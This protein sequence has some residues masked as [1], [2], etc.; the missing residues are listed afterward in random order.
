MGTAGKTRGLGTGV[1][2]DAHDGPG[3]RGP[4]G[5]RDR[6]VA[7]GE[8]CCGRAILLAGGGVLRPSTP[9][10]DRAVAQVSIARCRA[11]GP[12]VAGLPLATRLPPSRAGG[13]APDPDPEDPPG[14]TPL[15]PARGVPD[16]GAEDPTGP[17]PAPDPGATAAGPAGG[18][19]AMVV[20]PAGRVPPPPTVAKT[21]AEAGIGAEML[22][23]GDGPA[24]ATEEGPGLTGSGANVGARAAAV[25]AGAGVLPPG[26]GAGVAVRG[27]SGVDVARLRV[28]RRC[29]DGVVD[30]VPAAGGGVHR[31]VGRAEPQRPKPGP[32]NE[33]PV[34]T[35][36]TMVPAR[37]APT[38]EATAVNPFSRID[39]GC[40]AA[41]WMN[42]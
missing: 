37:L 36:P 24:A 40:P 33:P 3:G 42:P 11:A 14:P 12:S 20:S 17:T 10:A 1:R 7:R 15:P 13:G 8:L 2:R 30:M 25:P 22:P 35:V 6:V 39:P 21:G 23:T 38:S 29:R 18:V 41:S 32:V 31:A 5:G 28:D 4:L 9:V 34:P 19:D 26:V 27:S 16:P